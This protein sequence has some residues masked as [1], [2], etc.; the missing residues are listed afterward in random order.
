VLAREPDPRVRGQLIDLIGPA[1][2]SDPRAMQALAAQFKQETEP[3][4]MKA[5]GRYVPANKL[6]S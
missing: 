3:M 5:I 6:G 4:L 2:A 1:C